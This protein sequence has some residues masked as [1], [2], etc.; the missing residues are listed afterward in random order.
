MLFGEPLG[1]TDWRS[2]LRIP[3]IMMT[4]A[5]SLYDHLDAE[6]TPNHDRLDVGSRFG[7]TYRCND[8]VGSYHTH[9]HVGGHLDQGCAI[10]G[11]FTG[12]QE[13]P[14]ANTRRK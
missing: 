7:G 4:H 11:S 6:G 12:P 10:S 1:G 3:E 2:R 5:E 14:W 9:T 8:V 13:S